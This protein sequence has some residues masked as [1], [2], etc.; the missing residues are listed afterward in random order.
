MGIS[1]SHAVFQT[2]EAKSKSIV[3][4]WHGILDM[5]YFIFSHLFF[6][7]RV[8]LPIAF[9]NFH[10]IFLWAFFFHFLKFSGSF[11]FLQSSIGRCKQRGPKISTSKI[12]C[13]VSY[14]REQLKTRFFRS[15]VLLC[16]NFQA[17][18]CF[19]GLPLLLKAKKNT[20]LLF[21]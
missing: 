13:P 1:P 11:Y 10:A 9:L 7:F 6:H 17:Y 18:N 19:H 4:S 16:C 20:K 2:N 21:N 3:A 14:W 5:A 8:S 15:L 12:F